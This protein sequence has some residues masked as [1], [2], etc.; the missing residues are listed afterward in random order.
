MQR[1]VQLLFS[2]VRDA[3]TLDRIE[4]MEEYADKECSVHVL[5]IEGQRALL[6]GSGPNDM[7]CPMSWPCNDK[8]LF[9]QAM[10]MLRI[11]R[12]ERNEETVYVHSD[13]GTIIP[14]NEIA[15]I[16]QLVQERA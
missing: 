2:D 8:S 6:D 7:V 1:L 12:T 3:P 15:R 4:P 13:T 14:G 5:L 16:T 10:R 9:G 11:Y